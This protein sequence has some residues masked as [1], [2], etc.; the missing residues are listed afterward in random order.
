ME[1]S[2]KQAKLH[3]KS[4]PNVKGLNRDVPLITGFLLYFQLEESKP[5]YRH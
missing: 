1:K 2:I 3:Y 4:R 5:V